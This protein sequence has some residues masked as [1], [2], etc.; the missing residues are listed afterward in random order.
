MTQASL[1]R[2]RTSVEGADL[3]RPRACDG[4]V[5]ASHRTSY[6]YA[7]GGKTS[8]QRAFLFFSFHDDVVDFA[9]LVESGLSKGLIDGLRGAMCLHCTAGDH[10]L[11]Y[12][13]I[14][15]T[16]PPPP[17]ARDVF[18]AGIPAWH[19]GIALARTFPRP[20]LH[21]AAIGPKRSTALVSAG[22]CPGRIAR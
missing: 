10:V 22:D 14:P 18:P 12:S 2:N 1:T 21:A 11:K 13:S 3:A 16:T 8:G 5:T 9:A 20:C 7:W 17:K 19:A 6:G 15:K 4:V